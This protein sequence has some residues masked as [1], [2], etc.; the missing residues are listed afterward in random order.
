MA[1]HAELDQSFI[2]KNKLL[3]QIYGDSKVQPRDKHVY[4]F[5]TQA[6]V[7]KRDDIEGELV[8]TM[9]D[10]SY[11]KVVIRSDGALSLKPYKKIRR[12]INDLVSNIQE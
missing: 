9:D 11:I 2:E 6:E 8:I 10:P 3:N 5:D 12:P 7:I 4:V 1:N